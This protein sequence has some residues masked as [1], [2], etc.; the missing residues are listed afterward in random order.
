MPWCLVCCFLG[1]QEADC[2]ALST[3]KLILR[4]YSCWSRSS[5]A[6]TIAHRNWD[7]HQLLAQL[8]TLIYSSIRMIETQIKYQSYKAYQ[9]SIPTG[10]WRSSKTI[11]PNQCMS[12]QIKIFQT[13]SQR[14]PCARHKELAHM[15]GMGLRADASWG[16]VLIYIPVT[17]IRPAPLVYHIWTR[18]HNHVHL[19][20]AFAFSLLSR[21]SID[22]GM[23][24]IYYSTIFT[25]YT[26]SP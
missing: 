18:L 17:Y 16:G 12:L 1:H 21:V 13:S 2:T 7:L 15:L 25:N 3:V 22:W 26:Y 14:D 4:Y 19:S 9:H 5:L 20:L 11:H 10:S 8:Y 24:S 6:S 23:H